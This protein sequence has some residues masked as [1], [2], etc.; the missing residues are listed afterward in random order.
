[1][2]SREI[3]ANIIKAGTAAPSGGNSQPWKFEV[4]GDEI[5]V[6][7]L[8][9]KDHPVLNFRYRGTWVAHG[10]LIEN[11]EIAAS[12]YGFNAETVV[13]PIKDG[14]NII[15]RITLQKSEL[16]PSVLYDSITRRV[17]NRKSFAL[18]SL[19]LDERSELLVAKGELE[20][21][22]ILREKSEDL[23]NLGKALSINE[24]VMLENQLLHSLFF[25]EIVWNEQEEKEKGGG[26]FIK[27]LEL[28]PPQRFMLGLCRRWRVMNLLNKLGMARLIARDNAKIYSSASAMGIIVVPD[29]DDAFITAGRAMERIWLM[30]THL[31]L[32][33]HLITGILFFSQKIK[34]GETQEFSSEHI[35]MIETAY[36]KVASIFEVKTG[37]I[38]LL[39]RVGRGEEPSARSLKPVPEISF[40]N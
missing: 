24:A 36:K 38:A 29:T 2:V 19:T 1:M 21:G 3:I 9:L 35:Q 13:L 32:S 33:F 12:H 7:A 23:V 34:A 8:P 40:M 10:A 6:I 22:V 25:K 16:T 18:K 27:T 20:V 30:A 37:V 31:G 39:F 11:I 5:T 28:K 15:V 17:T 4:R 26:L 14:K